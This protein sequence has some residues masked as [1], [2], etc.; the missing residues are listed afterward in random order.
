M[1]RP[2]SIWAVI[3]NVTQPKSISVAKD[4]TRFPAGRFKTDGPYSGELFREQCLR[5]ALEQYQFL[6]VDLDGVAGYGSSFL[7]EAFGGLVRAKVVS[8]EDAAKRIAL[9]ATDDSLVEE[10]KGYMSVG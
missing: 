4:F 10:I 7:D 5:P 1:E 2:R 9:K 3:M 8:P 6:E